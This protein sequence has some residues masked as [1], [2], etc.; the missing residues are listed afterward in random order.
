MLTSLILIIS[1]FFIHFAIN[2]YK[3]KILGNN[4]LDLPDSIRKIHSKPTYLI[5]GHFIFI[6]YSAFLLFLTD[7]NINEKFLLFLV[8]LIIF[9]I[10]IFDDLKD[11]KPFKKLFFVLL[12][13]LILIYLDKNYLLQSI[14]LETFDKHFKFGGYSYI[15][16]TLCILLLINAINLI[17]GINGLAMMIFIIWSLFI[18]YFLNYEL[19]IFLLIFYLYIFIQI[20]KGNYFLGNSGSL[21]IGA[22]IGFTSIKAYNLTSIEKSSAE[23]LVILFLVPGIDMFR[24]FIQRIIKKRNPFKADKTHLHHLLLIKKVPLGKILFIYFF[25]IVSSSYL[26]FNNYFSEYKIL[27]CVIL[28]YLF[29]FFLLS[30]K[31]NK[32]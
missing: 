20:Y 8:F 14:Y 31:I 17:D 16:S 15:I 11:I 22:I 30:K 29:S 1:I 28:I 7:E 19:N 27:I 12:A 24:L 6:S 25:S 23:D 21:I 13:Y 18:H 32:V 3:K 26:A 2:K 9:F 5:G 10:G 4:F